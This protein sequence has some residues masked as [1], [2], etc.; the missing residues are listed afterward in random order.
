M[1]YV[2]AQVALQKVVQAGVKKIKEQPEIIDDI[3]CE[4]KHTLMEHSYGVTYI[5][6]IKDW[7]INTK[8]PVIQS[9]SFNPQR[10]PCVSIK[11]S[12]ETEKTDLEAIGDYWGPGVLGEHNVN[13]YQV[14]LDI[15]LHVTKQGDQALWLYYIVSYILFTH[16]RLLEELGLQ[17]HTFNA[18]ENTKGRQ[19]EANNIW[20]RYIRFS[21][22]VQNFAPGKPFIDINDI[23]TVFNVDDSADDDNSTLHSDSGPDKIDII[24]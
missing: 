22:V 21:A 18:S 17:N 6:G 3:F 23:R 12:N 19:Y 2:L 1:S 13:V 5:E 7:F 15:G 14:N 8:I 11:L 24:T 10:V 20:N 9:W 4:Y 16:K